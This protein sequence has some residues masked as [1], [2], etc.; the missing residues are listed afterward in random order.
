MFVCVFCRFDLRYVQ[1]VHSRGTYGEEAAAELGRQARHSSVCVAQTVALA[2]GEFTPESAD[3]VVQVPSLSLKSCGAEYHGQ[4]GQ[5][6][7]TV[8]TVQKRHG[9]T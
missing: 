4:G 6:L 7:A 9:I 2:P 8:R 5:C 3:R 1:T